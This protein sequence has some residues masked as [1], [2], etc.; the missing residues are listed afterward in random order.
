M[1]REVL[2]PAAVGCLGPRQGH[3]LGAGLWLRRRHPTENASDK[4]PTGTSRCSSASTSPKAT[5]TPASAGA[6]VLARTC[7]T[8]WAPDRDA[9][10][11][12][13]WDRHDQL[14][15]GRS[16]GPCGLCDGPRMRRAADPPGRPRT[17][18]T[19]RCSD[20]AR[21][22]ADR[23]SWTTPRSCWHGYVG[24]DADL[25]ADAI[26]DALLTSA[27]WATSWWWRTRRAGVG[28]PHSAQRRRQ[29]PSADPHRQTL[30]SPT[31]HRRHLGRARAEAPSQPR[32]P[33]ATP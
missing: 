22:N 14:G 7:A 17:P 15:D 26:R 32:Q 1:A 21:R 4:N 12:A 8:T 25:A 28:H 5:T 29:G 13:L 18:K 3:A 31:A 19:P 6:E 33:G 9:A 11:H 2:S 16:R 30:D 27:P 10:R 20:Y 23:L 24:R